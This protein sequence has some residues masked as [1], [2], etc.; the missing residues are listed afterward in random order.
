MRDHVFNLRPSMYG[1]AIL[2]FVM[3]TSL[4]LILFLPLM[5]VYQLILLILLSCYGIYIARRLGI[6][7]STRLNY[8]QDGTWL[9]Q[10]ANQ[11]IVGKLRGDS[12]ITTYVII[13]RFQ[14]KE[15]RFPINCIVFRDSLDETSYRQ[16]LMLLQ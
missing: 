11:V 8:R 10:S 3:T 14:S 5:L 6:M 16:L 13:L 7:T 9:W 12:T 4:A 2:L 1:R 15:W